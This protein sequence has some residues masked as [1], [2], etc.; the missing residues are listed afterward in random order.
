MSKEFEQLDHLR[1][2][3]EKETNANVI[4]PISFEIYA[5]SSEERLELKEAKKM[6]K[7]GGLHG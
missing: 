4:T 7:R 6:Y 3:L 5:K 2:A 1:A